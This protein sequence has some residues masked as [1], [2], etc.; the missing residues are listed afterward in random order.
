MARRARDGAAQVIGYGIAERLAA[1]GSAVVAVDREVGAAAA[2]G[3]MVAAGG[4]P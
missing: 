4:P 3:K 1:D 2:A